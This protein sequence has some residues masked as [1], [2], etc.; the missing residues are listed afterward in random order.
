MSSFLKSSSSAS[1]ALI[2][3]DSGMALGV[4]AKS[5]RQLRSELTDR[6]RELP[7]LYAGVRAITSVPGL[8]AIAFLGILCVGALGTMLLFA[9]LID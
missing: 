6:R 4:Q 5:F 9:G 8:A 1:G 2:D 3:Y 7:A